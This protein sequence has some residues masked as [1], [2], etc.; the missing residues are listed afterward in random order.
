MLT[1]S[2]LEQ[3][4]YAKRPWKNGLGSTLDIAVDDAVPARFRLSAADVPASGPFSAYDGYERT[5]VLLEGGPMTLTHD[6]V[7]S[8]PL[9]PLDIEVFQGEHVTEAQVDTPARD[10]NVFTQQ[11]KAK[12]RVAAHSLRQGS[13]PPLPEAA[14]E[15]FLSCVSGDLVVALDGATH[16]TISL[17][18]GDTVRARSD[19]DGAASLSLRAW[20]D[21][22]C[23]LVAIRLADEG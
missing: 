10:L 18:A 3:A 5:L 1:L 12:A 15:P 14:P 22:T 23:V 8:P 20:S 9:H 4:N 13:P 17:R 2:L 7:A 11:G 16:G 19:G 6:G 21:A